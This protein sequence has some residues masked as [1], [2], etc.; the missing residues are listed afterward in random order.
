MKR[1]IIELLLELGIPASVS[2]FDYL[3]RAIELSV[4][5]KLTICKEVY[6]PIAKEFKTE[7]TRVERAIRHAVT[8]IDKSIYAKYGGRYFRNSD[9]ICTLALHFKE[10]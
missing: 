9:V 5:N 1:K 8:K 4:D 10:E 7:S 3:A 6:E 2:G